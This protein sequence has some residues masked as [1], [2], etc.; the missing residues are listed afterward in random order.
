MQSQVTTKYKKDNDLN[1]SDLDEEQRNELLDLEDKI[2]N[3]NLSRGERRRH[4]NKRNVLKIK[5]KKDQELESQI[6]KISK[7]QKKILY[8]KKIIEQ[9]QHYKVQRDALREENR[10]IKKDL[11][12]AYAKIKVLR[13]QRDELKVID[14][15]IRDKSN[16]KKTHI[17][18][19]GSLI[20][21]NSAF[22]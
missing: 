11:E 1:L 13:A 12:E 9:G 10:G 15:N 16:V 3:G 8:Q 2:E 4:Q 22:S 5:Y 18:K 7:L 17:I 6:S 19:K 21:Q 20:N 14:R